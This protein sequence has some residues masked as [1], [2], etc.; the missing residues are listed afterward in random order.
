MKL[1]R[2]HFAGAKSFESAA[3]C[4]VP[5]CFYGQK[6]CVLY[7]EESMSYGC[8]FNYWLLAKLLANPENADECNFKCTG[9]TVEGVNLTRTL[10]F[11]CSH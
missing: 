4:V 10:I 6:C 5:V 7:C 8:F 11:V 1:I 3:K 9:A 2:V